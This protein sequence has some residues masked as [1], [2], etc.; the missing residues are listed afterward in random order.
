MHRHG[1][2]DV[3]DVAHQAHVV[4]RA[5]L[6]RDVRRDAARHDRRRVR[7]AAA[8]EAVHLARVARHLQRLEVEAAGERVERPHDVGD[9]LVAVDVAVRRGRVLG[10]LEQ[11]RIGLLDHL[12]A[13]V[14]V[15][16]AVVEDRVVE[17]EVGRLGQVVGVVAELRRLHAVGHVLVQARA[18]AVIVTADATDAARDEVGVARVDALH[19]DVEAAEHH[20]GAVA[21]EH[22]LVGEVDLRVDAEAAH[23]PRDRVPRHL[24]DDDL[25]TLGGLR[26]RHQCLF[27]SGIRVTGPVYQRF[28]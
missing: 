2:L 15:R 18:G 4:V 6:V 25:L 16:H 7:V 14:D 26:C 27:S 13:E 17:H 20:R 28:W 22:L 5:G 8:E 21:L 10:R 11:R 9:R 23:D 19:E 24:L 12:L 3:L 1:A